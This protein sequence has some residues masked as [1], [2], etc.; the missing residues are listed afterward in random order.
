[1]LLPD[2]RVMCAGGGQPSPPGHLDRKEAEIFS[3]PYLF[4]GPRPMI[5]AAPA[6]VSYGET[7]LVETSGGAE[8]DAVRLIGL[9]SVTHA[10]NASQR[11]APLVPMV[12][13]G[14]LW[15]TVPAEST[16]CPPGPYLMFLVTADGV[17]SEARIVRV[18]GPPRTDVAPSRGTSLAIHGTLPQPASGPLRIW[19]T[20]ATQDPATLTLFDVTGREI[21][22]EEVGHLG[23][24]SHVVTPRQGPVR[25]GIYL[26]RLTQDGRSVACRIAVLR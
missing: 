3:P 1:L 14:G 25:S 16:L 13:A 7:F 6:S 26:A 9:S 10:F 18:S 15:A 24:G 4:R 17:P 2:G 11:V 8:V 19:L 22:S 23:V 5:T 12:A 20:L 21:G